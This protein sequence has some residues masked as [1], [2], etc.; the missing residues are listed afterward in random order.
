MMQNQLNGCRTSCKLWMIEIFENKELNLPCC[1]L[2]IKENQYALSHPRK[3]S[4]L[5]VQGNC[6][7]SREKS[8]A[9]F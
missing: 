1:C 4:V 7:K 5:W 8:I 3:Y 6:E 9:D 2:A